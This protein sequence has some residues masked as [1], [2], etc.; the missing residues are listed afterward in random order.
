LVEARSQEDDIERLPL[1]GR[2]ASVGPWRYAVVDVVVF[3]LGLGARIDAAAVVT[4]GRLHAEAVRD[5]DLIVPVKLD[6]RVRALGNQELEVHLQ[7]AVFFLGVEIVRSSLGAVI[8][9]A[10]ALLRDKLLGV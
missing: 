3:R 7:V 4:L 6:A 5:L 8:V 10:L 1:A 2:L 9:N